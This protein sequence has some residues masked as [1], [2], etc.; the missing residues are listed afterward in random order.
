MEDTQIIALYLS[1]QEAAIGETA[2]KY[3]GYINRIAY[4][5][6]R[7]REDTEEIASDTYLAAWNAIPPE[8]PRVLKHFLS[9]IAR[10][11]AF[12]RLDY[13]TAKRRDVHMITLLSEL[14]ACLPDP[15]SDVEAAVDAKLAAGS[16]N[17]FLSQLDKKDCAVFLSRYYYSLTI[18]EIADKL[19]LTERNVKYRLSC[20][21]QKLRQQLERE[22]I[23]V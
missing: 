9:R 14:D 18:A 19:G 21:R 1:R 11:L 22:G 8:F 16:V 20:L 17:R 13:I 10:N 23:N 4:N 2:K 7:C 12:D 5:I 3:G 6:L 15:R